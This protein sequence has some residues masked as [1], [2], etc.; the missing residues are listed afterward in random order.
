M[1]G[2]AHRYHR[3][4]ALPHSQSLVGPCFANPCRQRVRLC[5]RDRSL[6]LTRN[7][8]LSAMARGASG[9]ANQSWNRN[10]AILEAPF[11]CRLPTCHWN[12]NI[13]SRPRP[14]TS[15]ALRIGFRVLGYRV[16]FEARG[17]SGA[18]VEARGR[19]ASSSASN[20]PSDTTS[21][22][23][24]ATRRAATRRARYPNPRGSSLGSDHAIPPAMLRRIQRCVRASD[25]LFDLAIATGAAHRG[26]AE[27][28]G[29]VERAVR[30]RDHQLFDALA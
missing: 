30:A 27:A 25:Q 15:F 21:A 13:D 22:E 1:P 20:P 6:A 18:G 23:V 17:R 28:G 19:R 24:R 7:N 14:P 2:R 11:S 16:W 29:H 4:A 10:V 8:A 26:H 3:T 5:T 9:K 12:C